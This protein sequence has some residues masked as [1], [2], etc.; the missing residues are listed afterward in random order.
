MRC[1][2]Q[3]QNSTVSAGLAAVGEQRRSLWTRAQGLGP[4]RQWESGAKWIN[5]MNPNSLT[6]N[7][8]NSIYF[9]RQYQL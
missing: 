1:F 4:D 8:D 5:L 6:E 7:E 3:S 2:A 9:S